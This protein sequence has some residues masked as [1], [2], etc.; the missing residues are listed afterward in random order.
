MKTK[1]MYIISIL[2]VYSYMIIGGCSGSDDPEIP[3][4]PN[5]DDT[6]LS[7]IKLS[8][9]KLTLEADGKDAVTF[10]VKDNNDKDITASCYIRNEL[11][12]KYIGRK[13]AN[14]FSYM[15]NGKFTFKARYEKDGKE[16][17]SESITIIVQNRKKYEFYRRKV[18]VFKMT[19]T[20]CVNC[21]GMTTALDAA[22]KEMPDRIVEMALHA[23]TTEDTDPFH[24]GATADFATA[25]GGLSGFPT[26]VYDLR[27]ETA[28]SNSS[29]SI[30]RDNIEEAMRDYP[31]TCGIKINS[32]YDASS[33]RVRVNASLKSSVGGSYELA[34]VLVVD[35]LKAPQ[36]GADA[37]YIHNHTV[38][39]LSDNFLGSANKITLGAG[40]EYKANEFVIEQ[41]MNLDPTKTRIVVYAIVK[42]GSVQMI[43]NIAE[44]G[45]NSSID[46]IE[47]ED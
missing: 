18:A 12:D 1:L 33:A 43:N 36:M 25:M 17:F 46:Y 37:N 44:C 3:G 19:G 39:A 35:G 27:K 2:L 23:S 42:N 26:C 15:A 40:E 10:T 7:T 34:Y 8:A 47:N 45:I 4:E 41:A 11:I 6:E 31:A 24:M 30:F 5:K 14:S 20:W 22:R 38:I 13:G 21:P 16:Y 29:L 32:T 9:S 28:T